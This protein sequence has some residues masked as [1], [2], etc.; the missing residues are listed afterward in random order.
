MI[1]LGCQDGFPIVSALVY[2]MQGYQLL[3]FI[4][5]LYYIDCQP[6]EDIEHLPK[7][8]G[9]LTY[10]WD[11]KV[12]IY[13]YGLGYCWWRLVAI[14]IL[15]TSTMIYHKIE[16]MCPIGWFKGHVIIKF[17]VTVIPLLEF[18]ICSLELEYVN[19]SHNKWNL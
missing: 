19:W 6:W 12:V 2:L 17:V 9:D 1:Y 3:W 4:K 18:D 13:P 11:P 7:S 14:G 8:T 5:L 15:D 16:T 10:R